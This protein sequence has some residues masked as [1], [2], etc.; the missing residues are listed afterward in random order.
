MA[1]NNQA[2]AKSLKHT[3]KFIDDIS[4]LNDKGN[5]IF[6]IE[7]FTMEAVGLLFSFLC[8]SCFKLGKNFGKFN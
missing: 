5:L 3:F 4:P 7:P 1:K 8:I 2:V 6:L